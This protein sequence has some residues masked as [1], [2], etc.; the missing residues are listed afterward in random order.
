V[1]AHREENVDSDV[2]LNELLDA[3]RAVAERHRLP[4]AA[5]PRRG[6]R[7]QPAPDYE[8]EDVSVKVVRTIFSYTDFV[9]RRVWMK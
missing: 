5:A 3:L 1:S 7:F 6:R 2:N 8:A 9:N 4:R